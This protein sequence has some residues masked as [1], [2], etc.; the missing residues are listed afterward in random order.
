MR[1]LIVLMLSIP[2]WAFC[3]HHHTLGDYAAL[4]VSVKLN[5]HWQVDSYSFATHHLGERVLD[6]MVYP[7]RVTALYTEVDLTYLSHVSGDYTVSYTFERVNPLDDDY[8]NEH[9]VWGQWTYEY[10]LTHS[11]NIKNRFRFDARFIQQRSLNEEGWATSP[12]FEH[13]L[14][15][16]IGTTLPGPGR[17]SPVIYN[18]FFFNTFKDAPAIYGENWAFAGIHLA[19]NDRVKLE[20]GYQNIAWVRNTDKDWLIQHYVNTSVLIHI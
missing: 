10:A 14:R 15:Y 7:Q 6:E 2:A 1:F 17:I 20:L 8:R 12:V 16:L 11:V 19:L 13:R 9:R 3:Q 4:G 5:N 18:E